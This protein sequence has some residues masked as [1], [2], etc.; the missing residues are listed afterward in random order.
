MQFEGVYWACPYKDCPFF[1]DTLHNSC[2]RGV[3]W[4]HLRAHYYPEFPATPRQGVVYAAPKFIAYVR[5]REPDNPFLKADQS[6][7]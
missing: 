6:A 5:G 1:A 2:M 3:F 4:E 7:V